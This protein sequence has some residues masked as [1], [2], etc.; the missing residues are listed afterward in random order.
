MQ[1]F[2]EEVCIEHL[3]KFQA[4]HLVI[5]TNMWGSEISI[6]HERSQQIINSYNL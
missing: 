4:C 6:V 1:L 5:P 3:F 2:K